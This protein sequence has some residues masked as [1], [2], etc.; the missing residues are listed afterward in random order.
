MRIA[1]F[2]TVVLS[3]ALILTATDSVAEDEIYRWVDEDGVVHFG[4]QP[5]SHSNSEAVKLNNDPSGIAPASS[6][7][8]AT[9]SAQPEEKPLTAAQQQ[10]ADR[11]EQRKEAAAKKEAIAAGCEQRHKLVSQ[12][13]PSTRVIVQYEDGTVGRLD[14][15]ERLEMLNEA[16]AYI[17]DNCDN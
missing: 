17:A 14:D 15:N 3:A 16:K 13:E 12:L 7:P 1:T 11:A 10:R 9:N 8:A 2:F 4:D 5:A 6:A